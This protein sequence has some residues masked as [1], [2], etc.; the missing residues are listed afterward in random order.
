MVRQSQERFLKQCRAGKCSLVVLDIPL[1]FET[2]AEARCHAVAVV[3]A[4]Q[5]LQIQRVLKRQ[6]M[7]Q[8]RVKKILEAQMPDEEKRRLADWIIP[9]GQGKRATFVALRRIVETLRAA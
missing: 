9:T 3:S 8:D 2:G 4:P 7:S 6:G 5:F 1:L